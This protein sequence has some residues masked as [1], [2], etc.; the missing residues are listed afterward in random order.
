ME[1][2]LYSEC[3]KVGYAYVPIQKIDELYSPEVALSNGTAFPELNLPIS[4]YGTKKD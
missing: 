1:K 2:C 4:V 3:V